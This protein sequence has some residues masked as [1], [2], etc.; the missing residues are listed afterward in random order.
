MCAPISENRKTVATAIPVV[1][2]ARGDLP[3]WRLACLRPRTSKN[4]FMISTLRPGCIRALSRVD[5]E[6]MSGDVGTGSV[7]Q[8]RCQSQGHQIERHTS[9][10]CDSVAGGRDNHDGP[11]SREEP[12]TRLPGLRETV[13]NS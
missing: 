9:V 7:Q 11:R 8:K 6:D 1:S 2:H 5:K 3:M 12:V 10:E 13:K 4:A